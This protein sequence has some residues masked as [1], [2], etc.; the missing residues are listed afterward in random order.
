MYGAS[1]HVSLT[2]SLSIRRSP[3]WLRFSSP[4]TYSSHVAVLSR[5]PRYHGPVMLGFMGRPE[6]GI[7]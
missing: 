5:S 3:L 1:P 6:E 2:P 7:T 4:Q